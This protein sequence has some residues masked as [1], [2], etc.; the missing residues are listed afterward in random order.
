MGKRVD[1][2]GRVFGR[3]TVIEYAGS[4][5][6]WQAFWRCRC[7]CGNETVVLGRV[8]MEFGVLC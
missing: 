1:L 5:K 7:E 2:T 3:L 4:D 6:K 8:C